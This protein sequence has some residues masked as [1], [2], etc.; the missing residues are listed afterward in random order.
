LAIQFEIVFG[1]DWVARDVVSHRSAEVQHRAGRQ[2]MSL[3]KVREYPCLGAAAV[4]S[5]CPLLKGID[6]LRSV[7]LI[8]VYEVINGAQDVIKA[9][10]VRAEGARQYSHPR[11]ERCCIWFQGAVHAGTDPRVA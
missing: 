10:Y 1:V 6:S 5:G 8:L 11:R 7:W 4:L 2:R 3:R 9:V